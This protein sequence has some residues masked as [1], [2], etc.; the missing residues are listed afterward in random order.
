M[1][2]LLIFLALLFL[3]SCSTPKKQENILSQTQYAMVIGG[4][5]YCAGAHKTDCGLT[6]FGCTDGHI[7]LCTQN[8]VIIDVRDLKRSEET[9]L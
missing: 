2:T 6:L 5:F 3:P 4:M 1:K 7:Y 9:E 8:V